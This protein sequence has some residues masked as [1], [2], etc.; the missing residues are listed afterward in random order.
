M[1]VLIFLKG[2]TVFPIW[3]VE[4]G[5]QAQVSFELL[6]FQNKKYICDVALKKDDVAHCKSLQYQ[7]TAHTIFQSSFSILHSISNV[8][9]FWYNAFC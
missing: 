3:E 7:K 6:F 1:I 5:F 2:T 4:A 9:E 8:G